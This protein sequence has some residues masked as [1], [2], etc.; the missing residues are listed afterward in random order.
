M[1]MCV[2]YTGMQAGKV[3]AIRINLVHFPGNNKP[4]PGSRLEEQPMGTEGI[5]RP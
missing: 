3:L 4:S 1:G 2:H 5:F